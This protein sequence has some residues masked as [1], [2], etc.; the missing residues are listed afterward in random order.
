L[1]DLTRALE[2][3]DRVSFLGPVPFAR[4]SE[5][6]GHGAVF[7]NLSTTG[8]LDKAILESMASGCIPVSRNDSFRAIAAE[9]ALER[10]VPGPGPEGVAAT[11]GD[12]AAMTPSEHSALRDRLRLIVHE[13]HSLSRLAAAI[14]G[15]LADLAARR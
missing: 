7:L 8:S 14:Y 3:Q 1:L 4:I 2:L 12:I 15:E 13:E 11:L 5:E 10:L 9:H 6:Y